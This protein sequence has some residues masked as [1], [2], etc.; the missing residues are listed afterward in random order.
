MVVRELTSDPPDFKKAKQRWF[1]GHSVKTADATG[2]G[3]TAQRDSAETQ[4]AFA[5][6]RH[7]A[8][9]TLIATSFVG[10]LS[11]T[12]SSII[13]LGNLQA[14]PIAVTK[15]FVKHNALRMAVPGFLIP[16]TC[17][18]ACSALVIAAEEEMGERAIK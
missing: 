5:W 10:A 6:S 11:I 16:P 17:M 13:L 14:I 4:E 2:G 15:Q 12:M 8:Y 18:A 1:G 9:Y 3:S 7:D